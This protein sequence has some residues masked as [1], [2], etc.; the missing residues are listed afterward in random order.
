M[1]GLTALI[2]RE[3]KTEWRNRNVI[4]GLLLYSFS[5]ILLVYFLLYY[6]STSGEPLPAL[7]RTMIFWLILLFSAV[8]AVSGSFFREQDGHFMYHYYTL[9]PEKYLISKFIVNAFIGGLLTIFSVLIFELLIPGSIFRPEL[10]LAVLLLGTLAFSSLFTV[11]SS[12][13]ARAGTNTGMVTIIGFPVVIPLLIYIARLT[14]AALEKTQSEHLI[15]RDL[16]ILL[17]FNLILP[18]LGLVLFPYIWRE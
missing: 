5:S 15:G 8:N 16:L 12:L 6:S 14:I 17:A 9:S 11:M 10:Y 4:A 7:A 3:I 13:A 2:T 1:Q 18:I